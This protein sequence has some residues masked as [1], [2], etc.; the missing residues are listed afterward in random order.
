MFAYQKDYDK[1]SEKVPAD[2]EKNT[3]IEREVSPFQKKALIKSDGSIS[4]DSYKGN[5]WKSS[6][7]TTRALVLVNN[8]IS[9]YLQ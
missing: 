8:W 6:Y 5:E 1:N 7:H 3:H 2:I 9:D 4:G